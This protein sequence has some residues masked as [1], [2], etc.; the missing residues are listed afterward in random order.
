MQPS[1][2]AG[3]ASGSSCAGRVTLL[4]AQL[5]A[6]AV[7]LPARPGGQPGTSETLPAILLLSLGHTGLLFTSPQVQRSSKSSKGA[8]RHLGDRQL[9]RLVRQP[10]TQHSIQQSLKESPVNHLLALISQ[11]LLQQV[12]TSRSSIGT[13]WPR[14]GG[15][16]QR[17]D[18]EAG[19]HG[20]R[21]HEVGTR[22]C[23]R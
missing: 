2:E 22:H 11:G 9:E 1:A 7:L 14:T 4:P 12:A 21:G 16:L 19:G 23:D 15:S 17:S 6:H 5:P 18:P 8:E 13:F 10:R 20:S 3:C